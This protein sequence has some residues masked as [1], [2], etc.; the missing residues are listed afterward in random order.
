MSLSLRIYQSD[1]AYLKAQ[2]ALNSVTVARTITVMC[3]IHELFH[4]YFSMHYGLLQDR[5]SRPMEL[6]NLNKTRST[7]YRFQGHPAVD[8]LKA[9]LD[10]EKTLMGNKNPQA[11][12]L[13]HL[14][15][16]YAVYLENK[17]DIIQWY[18]THNPQRI[19]MFMQQ[20]YCT[21]DKAG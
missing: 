8:W 12:M 21:Y 10:D 7:N 17:V 20:G 2:S 4:Q 6:L 16:Q 15:Y 9:L 1:Y 11:L 14:I 13:H 18:Q 19:E 5:T 3:Q